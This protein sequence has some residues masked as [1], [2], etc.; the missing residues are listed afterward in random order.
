MK[1]ERTKR[2]REILH[3]SLFV[4]LGKVKNTIYCLSHP[5]T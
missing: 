2:E 4:Y 5:Q 1:I 3:V